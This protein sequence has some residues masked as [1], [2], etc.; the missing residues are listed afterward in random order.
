MK[1]SRC[2]PCFVGTVWL[3]VASQI[4]TPFTS[5]AFKIDLSQHWS[6]TRRLQLSAL[7]QI[8]LPVTIP[9]KVAHKLPA[10]RRP[11][12][13]CR[14]R[15]DLESLERKTNS[16]VRVFLTLYSQLHHTV[17]SKQYGICYGYSHTT[18]RLT[19]RPG[20]EAKGI[21][22]LSNWAEPYATYHPTL[23]LFPDNQSTQNTKSIKRC[24]EAT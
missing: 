20:I 10:A 6:S 18:V 21:S 15:G 1:E 24:L 16:L 7:G 9:R 2:P 4:G 3:H 8:H 22:D 13:F 14:T 23:R 11:A 19:A 5:W 12:A 17:P